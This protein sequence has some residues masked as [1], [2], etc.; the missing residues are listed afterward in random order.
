M[1]LLCKRP[2]R[3]EPISA[4]SNLSGPTYSQQHTHP[5]FAPSRRTRR[6][7][8]LLKLARSLSTTSPPRMI[9]RIISC[10]WR[11]PGD[12]RTVSRR[13]SFTLS[14]SYPE[15]RV[16]RLR[17]CF[18]ASL[19]TFLWVRVRCN[20]IRA[21]IDFTLVLHLDARFSAAVMC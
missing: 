5:W 17:R 12:S 20:V 4:Q 16:R 7:I 9:S 8:A 10:N 21:R 13:Q 2:T 18:G 14:L 3:S 1:S 6:W 11:C 15:L 19:S